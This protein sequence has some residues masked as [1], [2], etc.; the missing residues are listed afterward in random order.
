MLRK[1]PNDYKYSTIG[2]TL[3]DKKETIWYHT[4]DG[5]NK[6]ASLVP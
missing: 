3:N 6:D 5:A 4:T 2:E 1:N